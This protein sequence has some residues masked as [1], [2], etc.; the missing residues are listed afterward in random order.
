MRPT[1]EGRDVSERE[2]LYDIIDGDSE[3]TVT[4]ELPGVRQE[5]I[6][7]RATDRSLAVDVSS[8]KRY[9]KLIELPE[10]VEADSMRWTFHNGV[11]DVSL[12]KRAQRVQVS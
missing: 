10:P 5:D 6:Y 4:V 7:L 11:L 1:V 3:I 9:W 12:R 2:P 8:S